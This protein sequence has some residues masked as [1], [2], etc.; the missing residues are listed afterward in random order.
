[1][2]KHSTS[3]QNLAAVLAKQKDILKKVAE[4]TTMS[5]AAKK[6]ALTQIKTMTQA[7][8]AQQAAL[9]EAGAVL[10]CQWGGVG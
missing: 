3:Q 6:A 2:S 10:V 8:N 5:A 9:K 4:S 1:M 7:V